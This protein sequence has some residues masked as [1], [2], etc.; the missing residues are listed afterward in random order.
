MKLP[1]KILNICRDDQHDALFL[2]KVNGWL[3]GDAGCSIQLGQNRIL[4]LFGDTIIGKLDGGKRKVLFPHIN[5]SIAITTLGSKNDMETQFYWNLRK[6]IPSSFFPRTPSGEDIYY[7]PTNGLFL[8][9]TLLIFCYVV[10]GNFKGDYLDFW[11]TINTGL[12]VVKNPHEDPKNWQINYNELEVGNDDFGIHSALYYRD[13]QIFLLGYVKVDGLNKNAFLA[14]VDGDEILRSKTINSLKYYNHKTRRFE[15]QMNSYEDFSLF[16]PGNTE[17][18]I[19]YLENRKLFVCTTY[20]PL[21]CKLCILTADEITGPWSGPFVVYENPDHVTMTYSF[22]IHKS[23]MRDEN[24][25]IFSYITSP[26]ADIRNEA[27]DMKFYRP[28]FLRM[29]ID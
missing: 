14:A 17:S 21:S 11:T 10:K 8:K 16:T 26:Y 6:G 28:R 13:T 15:I 2:P 20:N 1:F 12:I 22:R 7:W 3:G 24:T 25:I 29:D 27:V 4:W 5:N 23:L 9:E 18:S 19:C